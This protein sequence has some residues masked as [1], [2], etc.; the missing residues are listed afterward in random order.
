M[1]S[2][3]THGR[4]ERLQGALMPGRRLRVAA[5]LSIVVTALALSASVPE[6]GTTGP[7]AAYGFDEG[8]GTVLHD[9]SGNGNDGTIANGRWSA[10]GEHGGALDFDGTDT[11]VSVPDAPSLD[12]HGK[13]TVEAWVRPDALGGWRAI[14]VKEQPDELGY[15][16][17]ADSKPGLPAGIVYARHRERDT[18]G[19]AQLPV[20][21]WSHLAVTSDGS[22]LR[23]YVD[24]RLVDSTP[25]PGQIPATPGQLSI[26]GDTVWNEWFDGAIDDL[27]VYDR[28]LSADEVAADRDTAVTPETARPSAPPSAPT[29]LTVSDRTPTSVTLTWSGQEEHGDVTG[30]DVSVDGRRDATTADTT[31]T[32]TGLVCGTTHTFAVNAFDP[33]GAASDPVSLTAST[34]PCPPVA[35]DTPPTTP[36]GLVTSDA[37]ETSLTLAWSASSDDVG[38]AGYDVYRDGATVAETS[39]TST[40]LTDLPCGT[41]FDLEVDAYDAAGNRSPKAALSAFTDACATTTTTTTPTTTSAP[42]TTTSP[43][44]TTTAGGTGGA[45]VFL[46]PTGS[47]GG[48]CSA[49]DPCLTFARAYLAARPGDT[50]QVA[51]GTYGRQTIVKGSQSQAGPSIVFACAGG[52]TCTVGDLTLGD[53]DGSADGD[54]PSYLT[55]DRIDVAG[56]SIYTYYNA[57]GDPVPSHLLYENAHVSCTSDCSGLVKTNSYSDFEL[58]NVELGPAC[59][60]GDGVEIGLPRNGAA[61]PSNVVLDRVYIHDIYDSCTLMPASLGPCSGTGYES[62]CGSCDHV[63]GVQ[64]Y[65][66]NGFTMTRSRVYA[67]NPGGDV[68]QGLF[69]QSANGGVFSDI[70]VENDLFDATPDNDVSISGPGDGVVHGKVQILYNTIRHNLELYGDQAGGRPFAS[71]T[72]VVVAGNVIEDLSSSHGNSCGVQAADGSLLSI[73]YVDN[74]VG[75]QACGPT[76]TVGSAVF[77]STDPRA[78]DLHLAPD[79]TAAI[80]RGESTWCPA[81]DVDGQK[82]PQGPACDLG[83]DEAR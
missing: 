18:F 48:T 74:L 42:T 38:V 76:D 61:T 28:T 57:N 26:G 1:A 39:G 55:F 67:I 69:L 70:L 17:Y 36:T 29:G 34:A 5:I 8:A 81:D 7:V 25:V 11:L 44:T 27:R 14:A 62:G 22:T 47:D 40:S 50:V 82:R 10:H 45:T 66:A 59:C 41:S 35:D 32:V 68:G 30:Y 37:T 80:D 23:L 77:V 72:Q 19:A 31:A 3:A 53:N 78:P 2:A 65:G 75:N 43:G 63:D 21:V 16:L 52:G 56:G 60:D 13:L 15:A 9:L 79:A 49:D 71:G 33:S 20:G 51:P 12:L 6:A 24:G 64:V 58:E 83:G 4:G 54:A 73:L 46:S